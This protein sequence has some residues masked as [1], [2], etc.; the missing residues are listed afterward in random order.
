MKIVSI[1]D[2]EILFDNG[3][4]ITFDHRP[5]CCEHNYAD[6]EQLDDVEAIGEYK[7][8][9]HY[10]LPCDASGK[11]I[12]GAEPIERTSKGSKLYKFGD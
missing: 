3:N 1:T 11:P 9:V 12:E 7:R 10:Y 6:F 2:E 8:N 4:T 5:D